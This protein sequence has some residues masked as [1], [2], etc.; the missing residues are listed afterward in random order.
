MSPQEQI[1]RYG[2]PF[3]VMAY[4]VKEGGWWLLHEE[5]VE[6]LQLEFPGVDIERHC[7]NAFDW[8]FVRKSRHKTSRGTPQFLRT[9]LSK[10]RRDK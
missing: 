4:P 6:R 8:V 1:E 9:W 10:Q 7:G 5:D 3:P 2:E